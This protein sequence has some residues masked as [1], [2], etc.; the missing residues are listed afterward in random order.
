[1]WVIQQD[2]QIIKKYP[3]KLQCII[4]LFLNGWVTRGWYA[5]KENYWINNPFNP[6]IPVKIK[7]IKDE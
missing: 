3:Y 7:E 6:D 1:M 5:S 4:W 2:K